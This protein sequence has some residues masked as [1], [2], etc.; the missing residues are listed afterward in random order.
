MQTDLNKLTGGHKESMI[1][2]DV[3]EGISNELQK[4]ESLVTKESGDNQSNVE[5]LW[6]SASWQ[7]E[8]RTLITHRTQRELKTNN[9][10]RE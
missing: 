8:G 5:Q 1:R 4:P 7:T 10:I 2:L 3:R 6:R 9:H